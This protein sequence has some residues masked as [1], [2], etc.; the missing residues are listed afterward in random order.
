MRVAIAPRARVAT[1]RA[2]LGAIRRDLVDLPGD[3]TLVVHTNVD[4]GSRKRAF[5]L[6]ASRSVAK[7]LKK[8]ESYV[9]VCVVDRADIVWGGS[10]DDCALCRL[11]SLGGIDLENNKAVSEDVC[12]LLGETFGIAGT[13]VYVTFEDVARENM[14]YDSATF[15]G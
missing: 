5:M 1:P 9:A 7:T 12:A 15:A 10:D 4:M 14:G 6:A 3:P 8:P 11:T 13:R 2:A